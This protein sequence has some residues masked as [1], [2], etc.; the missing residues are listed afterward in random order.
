MKFGTEGTSTW[1]TFNCLSSIS[2]YS[3]LNDPSLG[4]LMT[5]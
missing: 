5:P 2:L 1:T 4:L 3:I